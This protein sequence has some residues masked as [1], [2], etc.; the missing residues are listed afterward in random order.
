MDTDERREATPAVDDLCVPRQL[1]VEEPATRRRMAEPVRRAAVRAVIIVSLTMIQAMT[2]LL[3]TLSGA[4]LAFPLVLSTV[5]GTVVA[6]WAVLDVWVTRQ[7]W[8]QRNGVVSVPSST[9]RQL[10]RERR[11]A[12]RAARAAARGASRIRQRAG[13]RLSQ[14]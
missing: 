13:G 12:R 8:N 1:W 6:T 2:A 7:V 14:A 4:W 9:A 10:R 3:F 5:A 11:R